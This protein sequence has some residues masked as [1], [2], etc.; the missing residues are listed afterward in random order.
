MGIVC[1]ATYEKKY[2]MFEAKLAN[3]SQKKGRIFSQ[4]EIIAFPRY[5]R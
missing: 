2:G 3:V 1:N 4:G 5:Q